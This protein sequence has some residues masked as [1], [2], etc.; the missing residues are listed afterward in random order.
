L[1]PISLP[2]IVRDEAQSFGPFQDP[3]RRAT[4]RET[5]LRKSVALAAAA[6]VIS[7]TVA[8]TTGTT[9]IKARQETMEEMGQAMKTLGAIA[10]K[11]APFDT[12]VVTA[13]GKKI[14]DHLKKAADLFPEGSDKGDVETWAKAEIWSDREAFEKGLKTTT[15]AAVA[16]QS[17]AEEAAFTPALGALGNGCKT[18]HDMYRRPKK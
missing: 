1:I 9:A 6:A 2:S 11:Q 4:M 17:V 5:K 13:E 12:E 14:T 8:A 15:A 3:G 16:L 10:A 18:C 7:I